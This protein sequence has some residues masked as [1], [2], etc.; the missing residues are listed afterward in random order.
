MKYLVTGT[1]GFIGS[2]VA[3]RLLARGDA[4]TGLD[5]IKDYYVVENHK[6]TLK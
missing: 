5:S 2:Y 1:A 6:K 3:E 4:V